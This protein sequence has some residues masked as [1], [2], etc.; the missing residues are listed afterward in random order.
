M[1]LWKLLLETSKFLYSQIKKCKIEV[2]NMPSI[3]DNSKYWQVFEH[4]L[5]IKRFLDM[6]YEFS[7]TVIDRENQSLE[8]AQED[9]EFAET[10]EG[11]K[12]L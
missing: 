3:P 1:I 8:N 10:Y 6:S 4:D 12:N 7:N 5:Q 11:Q 9:E 2:V